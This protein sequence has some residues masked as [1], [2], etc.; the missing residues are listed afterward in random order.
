ML[1]PGE[2]WSPPSP[3]SR[4]AQKHGIAQH[5]NFHSLRSHCRHNITNV[6]LFKLISAACFLFS[7]GLNSFEKLMFT[8][9]LSLLFLLAASFSTSPPFSNSQTSLN[10]LTL[11]FPLLFLSALSSQSLLKYKKLSHK[12]NSVHYFSPFLPYTADVIPYVDP[13]WQKSNNKK[14]KGALLTALFFFSQ[15][16]QEVLLLWCASPRTVIGLCG[17]DGC[18]CS[19][20]IAR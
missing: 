14:K 2:I 8:P 9:E 12:S 6:L 3:P 17:V 20:H 11:I 15:E 5:I 10:R 18:V 7:K 1:Y 4:S 13:P 19:T 16:I